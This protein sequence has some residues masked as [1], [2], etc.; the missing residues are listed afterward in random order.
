MKTQPA[1]HQAH[2]EVLFEGVATE[3]RIQVAHSLVVTVHLH[4]TLTDA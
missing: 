4:Y 2:M 3:Q 1:N